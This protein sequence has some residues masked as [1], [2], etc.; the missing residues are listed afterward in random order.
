VGFTPDLITG[1]WAGNDDNTPMDPKPGS[2]AA[3][4]WYLFMSGTAD[5]GVGFVHEKTPIDET[6]SGGLLDQLIDGLFGG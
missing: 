6:P 4:L 5:S 1:V 2:P 3:K